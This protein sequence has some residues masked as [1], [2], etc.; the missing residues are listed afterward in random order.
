[1]LWLYAD[2]TDVPEKVGP[3]RSARPSFIQ[4]S[5][6]FD[7]IYVH[8]GGSHDNK[9]YKGGYTV[10]KEDKVDH[11]D[12]MKGGELYGR[13]ETR[14]GKVSSEHRGIVKGNKLP[15][16]IK[17]KG[18]RTNLDKSKFSSLE[19]N[20]EAQA[21]GDVTANT[22]RC[23]FSSKTDTRKFT[24]SEDGKKYH[25]QDWR[26]DVKFTNVIILKDE[27][28]Y[29]HVPYKGHTTTYL[30]YQFTGGVGFW[31]SQGKIS[32]INWAIENGKLVLKDK[33]G[34]PLKI[35]K[36]KSYIGLASANNEGVVSYE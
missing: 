31:A 34:N 18:F 6:L 12:G 27:T 16:V 8:W 4:F 7:S 2:Y 26:K 10:I 32:R 28:K 21:P 22:V 30:N 23:Q 17:E 15:S 5:E 29:I 11:I 35:N 3:I 14:K 1:M 36:G 13:D 19:F 25:T 33:Q 24:Y 9:G 20:D